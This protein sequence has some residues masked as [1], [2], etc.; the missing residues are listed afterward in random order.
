M[1]GLLSADGRDVVDIVCVVFG[2]LVPPKP[3][4][5]DD[6]KLRTPEQDAAYESWSDCRWNAFHRVTD[7]F[8]WS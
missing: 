1:R 7:Q 4:V 8:G 2:E 3:I 5:P 6:W